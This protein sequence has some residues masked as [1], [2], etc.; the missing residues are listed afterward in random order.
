VVVPHAA[1][2]EVADT[3]Q[4]ISD[5]EDMILAEAL[6]LGGTLRAAREHNHYHQLQ[7]PAEED[8]R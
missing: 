6:E 5:V 1:E 7:H 8:E 2:R 3:T 4:R